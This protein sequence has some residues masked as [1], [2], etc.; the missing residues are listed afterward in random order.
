M[1][2][3]VQILSDYNNGIL[4]GSWLEVDE[5]IEQGIRQILTRSVFPNV[6]RY[7]TPSGYIAETREQA[8]QYEY[9]EPEPVQSAE[10]WRI[11]DA[12]AKIEVPEYCSI[13]CLMQLAEIDA[14]DYPSEVLDWAITC[15][16]LPQVPDFLEENFMGQYE[17]LRD[18]AI[19]FSEGFLEGVSDVVRRHFCF[20]SYAKELQNT[21]TVLETEEG[22]YVFTL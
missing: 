7:R 17:D 3:Y 2:I 15:T 19:D 20:D 13:L 22:V 14:L 9:A 6:T 21:M 4:T 16:D 8:L 1:R 11:A 12:E 5:D 18:M 10:E